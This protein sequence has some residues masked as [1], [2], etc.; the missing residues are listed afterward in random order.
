MPVAQMSAAE[1]TYPPRDWVK[2]DYSGGDVDLEATLGYIP[3]AMRC[4]S[5]GTV[6]F[7]CVDSDADRDRN[8]A[9]GEVIS[10]F[11]TQIIQTGTDAVIEVAK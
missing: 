3:R 9:A 8:M 1:W 6:V 4:D 10:G 2:I 5:A 11:Y 7:R